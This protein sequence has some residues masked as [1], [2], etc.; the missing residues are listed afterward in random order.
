MQVIMSMEEY[1]Q[2][3]KNEYNFKILQEYI[4]I[5]EEEKQKNKYGPKADLL[6]LNALKENN[7]TRL[8]EEL[9]YLKNKQ[10]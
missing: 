8:D 1:E 2:L 10:A 5:Q 9:E 7:F 4:Q 3:K 6:L